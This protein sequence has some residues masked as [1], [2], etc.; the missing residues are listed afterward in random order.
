M[1][2]R[3]LKLWTCLGPK[4][5]RCRPT[6]GILRPVGLTQIHSMTMKAL[7]THETPQAPAELTRICSHRRN[8]FGK[9]WSWGELFHGTIMT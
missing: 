9:F 4:W 1:A 8:H 6:E 7:H 2:A 3:N 5:A